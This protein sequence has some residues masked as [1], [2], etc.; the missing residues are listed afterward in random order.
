MFLDGDSFPIAD[1]MPLIDESLSRA[2]LVAVR[3]DEN[4]GDPQPHPCFCVTTVGTWRA[5]PGDWSAGY[6]WTNAEGTR[7][8]DTGANLMRAL[9]LTN[10]PWIKVLRT[11]KRNPDPIY[12][13]IYGDVVY[14]HGAGFRVVSRFTR[15]H[16]SLAPAPK[17]VSGM[18]LLRTWRRRAE[19][20]R[21]RA[22]D[23]ETTEQLVR[24]SDAIY[25]R[26]Q[27]GDSA[28]LAELV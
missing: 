7:V 6:E 28:W 13:G 15:Y 24:L 12:F 4:L 3:R 14:H 16:G 2:P 5:L 27:N 11:N 9:E 17:P 23:E 18:P 10:T 22:W 21:R 25:T 1:P 19:W 8:S 20:K 26:I